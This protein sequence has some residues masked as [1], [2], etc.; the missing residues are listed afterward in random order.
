MV[1]RADMYKMKKD[2]AIY[3]K[4]QK[5]NLGDLDEIIDKSIN[6]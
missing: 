1:K 2:D 5:I 6:S 3:C 4:D